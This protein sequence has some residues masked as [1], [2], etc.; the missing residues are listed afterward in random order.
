MPIED[1]CGGSHRYNQGKV[2]VSYIPPSAINDLVNYEIDYLEKL[3]IRGL[4]KLAEHF[5]LGSSKYP[6]GPSKN[7]FSFPNWA[8]GQLFDSFLINSTERHILGYLSG[9]EYDKDFGSHHLIAVAWG[10]AC[11][12]H[13]FNNYEIYKSF[14]DRMWTGFSFNDKYNS[15]L[16]NKSDAFLLH[17][18]TKI[19]VEPNIDKAI[20]HTTKLLWLALSLFEVLDKSELTFIVDANRL[21]VIKN[22]Q[23]GT[24]SETVTKN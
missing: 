9:E 12:N 4:V 1:V 18:L 2:R 21:E 15:L 5:S 10:A 3:P 8:K 13:Q 17:L 16:V 24:P 14:D 11:L 6:D 19:Q 20:E 22:K 23:Y 7:G